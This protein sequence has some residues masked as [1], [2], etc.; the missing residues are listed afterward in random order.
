[1]SK[2]SDRTSMG[3][4]ETRFQ[5]TCWT[6]ILNAKT[7]DEPRRREVT[8]DLIKKYWKPVYCYLRRKGCSN[9]AAKDLTQGFFHEIVLGRDLIQPY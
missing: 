5:R 2:Q 8:N 9:E 4:A 3:G 7:L 6:D 1:M